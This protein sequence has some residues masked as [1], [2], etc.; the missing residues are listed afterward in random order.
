MENPEKLIV[1]AGGK[2]ACLRCTAL[3]KRT[4]EQCRKPALKI[5]GAQKCQFHGGRSTGPRSAEGKAR[6]G[7]AH[8][9]H[10]NDTND[11]RLKR[12]REALKLAQIEDVLHAVGATTATRS[13]G[14]K[15][16]GY[17]PIR[18][19]EEAKAW[20]VEAALQ[21]VKAVSGDE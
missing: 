5:S 18:T 17:Q 20:V 7:A 16:A 1:V 19:L 6:I 11:R 14:R 10:G 9:V 13:T 8:L 15:P 12:S 21:P 4:R 2:I 3:S